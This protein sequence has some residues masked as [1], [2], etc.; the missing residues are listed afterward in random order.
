MSKLK[1]LI[2]FLFIVLFFILI[3]ASIYKKYRVESRKLKREIDLLDKKIITIRRLSKVEKD[4]RNLEKHYLASD[5]F[6]LRKTIESEAEINRI[7]LKSLRPTSKTDR[8]L[9]L[10]LE[11]DLTVVGIYDDVVNFIKSL[12]SHPF[13]DIKEIKVIGTSGDNVGFNIKVYGLLR[14]G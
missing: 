5:F 9:F 6:L 14:K 10:E 2:V 3:G 11:V 1:N 13:I 12:E 4:I 8:G 7:D